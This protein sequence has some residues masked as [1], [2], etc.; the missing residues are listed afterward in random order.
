MATKG[1][2]AWERWELASF[3]NEPTVASD[4]AAASNTPDI[5]V[6]PAP[7]CGESTPPPPSA[8]ELELAALRQSTYDEAFAAGRHDGYADGHK[9][10]FALGE[11]AGRDAA[12]QAARHE[13]ER[14]AR[15]ATQLDEQLAGLDHELSQQLLDLTLELTRKLVGRTLRDQPEVVL[16][17]IRQALA[18]LPVQHATIHLHPDDAALVRAG[19]DDLITHAG[20]RVHESARLNP[21]DV[22]IEAAGSQLDATLATRWRRIVEAL[23]QTQSPA[24]MRAEPQ[25]EPQADESVVAEAAPADSLPADSLPAESLSAESPP[26]ESPPTES[27]PD[28]PP[29]AA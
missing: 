27:P 19:G 21:G 11:T 2:T 29:I 26:T 10:G 18:E 6:S 14:L 15:I 17:V 3:D 25:S 4:A 20:H 5:A 28:E 13:I 22:L 12:T 24:P 16:H 9:E 8:A 23:G 1:L 7:T